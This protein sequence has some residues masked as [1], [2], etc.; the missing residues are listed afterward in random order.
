MGGEFYSEDVRNIKE[1]MVNTQSN[2]TRFLLSGRSALDYI[3]RDAKKEYNFDTIHLPS[4]VCRSMIEPFI[5]NGI[6]VKF[7]SVLI[8]ENKYI[9]TLPDVEKKEALYIMQYFGYV[10]EYP[11]EIIG[12]INEGMLIIEDKTHIA[13]NREER[14]VSTYSFTSFRKWSFINGLAIAQKHK[15]EFLLSPPNQ[16]N[17]KFIELREKGALLKKEV[18]TKDEGYEKRFLDLFDEAERT[19]N[20]N[21]VNCSANVD[22]IKSLYSIDVEKIYQKRRENAEL[23]LNGIREKEIITP[24]FFE[25]LENDIPLCVPVLV[26]GSRESLRSFLAKASIYCPV[27][28]PMSDL[29]IGLSERDKSIYYTELSLI[30]DQ[31]YDEVDMIR[32]IEVI[33]EYENKGE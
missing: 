5:K 8:K 19:L 24:I 6:K 33:S 3:I 14:I 17:R 31:R 13:F 7:Y 1:E 22:A 4:L 10:R 15:G 30:C 9:I 25:V 2:H 29:H 18:R 12:F 28:W 32:L 16:T 27:H 23:L 20:N 21:Y 26:N 11:K